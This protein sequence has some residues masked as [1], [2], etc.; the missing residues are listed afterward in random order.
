MG[1]TVRD[2][3]FVESK[4]KHVRIKFILRRL[5]RVVVW[6]LG[7]YRSIETGTTLSQKVHGW[8]Y[9]VRANLRE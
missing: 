8:H 9:I 2:A 3:G 6:R 7:H 1:L 4:V 5:S